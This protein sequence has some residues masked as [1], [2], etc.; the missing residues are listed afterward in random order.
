MHATATL[1]AKGLAK[2]GSLTR[3]MEL[4][5]VR[6]R[7]FKPWLVSDHATEIRNEKWEATRARAPDVFCCNDKRRGW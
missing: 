1:E 2:V 7:V 3:A 6:G 4:G 5:V